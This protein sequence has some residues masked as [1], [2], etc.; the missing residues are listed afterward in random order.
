M[1]HLFEERIEGTIERAKKA[2]ARAQ[3][4][5]QES[6]V[7]ADRARQTVEECKHRRKP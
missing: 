2:V 1:P 3:K 4:R 5:V 7:L 6:K